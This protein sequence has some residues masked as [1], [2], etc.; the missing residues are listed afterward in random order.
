MPLPPQCPEPASAL[1]ELG[2]AIAC[3]AQ[4]WAESVPF[5]AGTNYD[6]LS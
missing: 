3:N 1:P 6:N 4:L 2:V 5:I